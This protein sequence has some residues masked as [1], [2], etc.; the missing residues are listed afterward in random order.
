MAPL[1]CHLYALE[2]QARER[3][4]GGQFLQPADPPIGEEWVAYGP[5]RVKGGPCD[6]LSVDDLADRHGADLLGTT[7]TGRFGTRFP[8]LVK[9]LDCADWLSVQVHPNDEQA[10]RMVGP[11]EFGKTEAWYFIST[12][13]GAKIMVGVKPGVGRQELIEAI[14]DGRILEVAR[15]LDVHNGESLLVPAGTLHALGP[16]LLIYEI[17]QA[18]DTTYR[19]YDWNRPP[20]TGRKLHIEE[21]IEATQAVG[22]AT[23][24]SPTVS[25]ETGSAIAA[26]CAY[27]DLHLIQVGADAGAGAGAGID[28][29]T[30]GRSFHLVTVIE[31][32]AEI[33]RGDERLTI[34][35]FGTV[36]VAAGAGQ[37]R[38][39]AVGGPIKVLQAAVT[40]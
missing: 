19:V 36:L 7:V 26:E 40:D 4:W 14:R 29:D 30:G 39:R 16:G 35:R 20:S 33:E 3:V 17:Q 34:G 13:A 15:I 11:N 2:P 28:A 31:G 37:Y 8:L 5:S 27:F 12:D 10:R 9:L 6:G 25:S 18:S 21:S 38:I 32:T 22:P 23:L 1:E 24:T